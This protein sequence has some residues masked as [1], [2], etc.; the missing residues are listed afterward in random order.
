MTNEDWT[1]LVRRAFRVPDIV[2]EKGGTAMIRDALF[3]PDLA[4]PKPTAAQIDRIIETVVARGEAGKLDSLFDPNP[5][6]FKITDEAHGIS[7][8]AGRGSVAEDNL[9][10]RVL[11]EVKTFVTEHPFQAAC[12][13]YFK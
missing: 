8:D 10:Q 4:E 11:A 5:T 9:A 13:C 12:G 1:R 3:T 6:T 2:S 7:L